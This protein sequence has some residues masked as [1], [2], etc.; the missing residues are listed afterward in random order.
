MEGK[1]QQNRTKTEKVRKE[2]HGTKRGISQTSRITERKEEII[3]T[4]QESQLR[5]RTQQKPFQTLNDIRKTSES[6]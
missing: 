5:K 6:E 3:R 2:G 4:R 1:E